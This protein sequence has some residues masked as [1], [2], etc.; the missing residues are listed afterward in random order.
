MMNMNCL[1]FDILDFHQQSQLVMRSAG[2]PC[3]MTDCATVGCISA[4]PSHV[5]VMQDATDDA[6]LLTPVNETKEE[7]STENIASS[8]EINGRFS[9]LCY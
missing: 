3:A 7:A 2:S 6:E 8:D 5:T 9:L 4:E 1:L